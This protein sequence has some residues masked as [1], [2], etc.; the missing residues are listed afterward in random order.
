MIVNNELEW[1][2]KKA[3]FAYVKVLPYLRNFLM[4]LRKTTKIVRIVY[5]QTKF[6]PVTACVNLFDRTL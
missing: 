5:S 1:V 3:D 6:T 2:W 4:G